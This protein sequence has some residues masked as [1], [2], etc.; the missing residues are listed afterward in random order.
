MMQKREKTNAKAMPVGT[1][2]GMEP[3]HGQR[4]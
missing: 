3:V 4:A 2:E 1:Q